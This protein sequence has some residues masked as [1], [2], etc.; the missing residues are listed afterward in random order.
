M[1]DGYAEVRDPWSMSAPPAPSLPHGGQ[2]NRFEE[3]AYHSGFPPEFV[4][5]LGGGDNDRRDW[6]QHQQDEVMT[7]PVVFIHSV[8]ARLS[9][10]V[11]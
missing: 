8:E 10:T 4:N 5:Q 3:R 2:D 6:Q 1:V 11:R 9:L 7:Q